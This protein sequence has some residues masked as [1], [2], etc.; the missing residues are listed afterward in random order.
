MSGQNDRDLGDT[1]TRAHG[2]LGGVA[3]RAIGL[4]LGRVDFQNEAHRAALDIQP[5]GDP[6]RD[7][8]RAADRI[9]DLFQCVQNAVAGNGHLSFAP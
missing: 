1:F 6:G 3:H 4:G 5:A 2:G 8:I 7:D 9:G